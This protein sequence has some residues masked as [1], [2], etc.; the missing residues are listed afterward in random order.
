VKQ[1]AELVSRPLDGIAARLVLEVLELG[2]E[3]LLVWEENGIKVL[4]CP[5]FEECT[6]SSTI[7]THSQNCWL[8]HALIGLAG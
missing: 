7:A 8:T 2:H 6:S 1:E 5:R 3:L 4:Q